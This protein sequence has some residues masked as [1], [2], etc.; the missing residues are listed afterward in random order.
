[1]GKRYLYHTTSTESIVPYSGSSSSER[2]SRSRHQTWNW[3]IGSPGQWVIWVI[4]HVRVTGSSF[5]PCVRPEF[6]RF[7]KNCPKCKTRADVRDSCF[8]RGAGVRGA[9]VNCR[10]WLTDD[11][12]SC[13][14]QSN[15]P[16]NSLPRVGPAAG[17]RCSKQHE[18]WVNIAHVNIA[19]SRHTKPGPSAKRELQGRV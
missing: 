10:A 4:F 16:A 19:T 2:V 12:N 17:C 13:S 6:F 18:R 7:S 11:S 5:R 14:P 8:R 1:M 9:N 15:V 3:V